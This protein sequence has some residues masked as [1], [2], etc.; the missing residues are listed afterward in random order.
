MIMKTLNR[1]FVRSVTALASPITQKRSLFE[2]GSTIPLKYL[3][4]NSLAADTVIIF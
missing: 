3:N 1:Y 4:G 2:V